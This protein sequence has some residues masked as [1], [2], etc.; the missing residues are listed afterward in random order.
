MPEMYKCPINYISEKENNPYLFKGQYSFLSLRSTS[1]TMIS[2]TY[3]FTIQ[4]LQKE[5][6]I[7]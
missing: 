7:H 4:Q 6:K 2:V 5:I 3:E 1:M